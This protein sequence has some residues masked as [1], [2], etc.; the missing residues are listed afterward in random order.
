MPGGSLINS[1]TV[2]NL[3]F[4][5]LT[6]VVVVSDRP[7]ANTTV[8]TV[9]AL[10]AGAS[11]NFAA[12]NTVPANACTVTTTVSGSGKDLC[13]PTTVTNTVSTTCTV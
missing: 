1:G 12:T 9:A 8:F 13:S 6:N 3:G 7:V 11:A 2:R 10:A 4:I 5:T